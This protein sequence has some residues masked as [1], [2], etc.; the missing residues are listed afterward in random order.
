MP[1]AELLMLPGER[2]LIEAV[3]ELIARVAAFLGVP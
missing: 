2:E 1:N 3:P